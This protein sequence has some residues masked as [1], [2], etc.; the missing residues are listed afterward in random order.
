MFKKMGLCRV[1]SQSKVK[2]S[3]HNLAKYIHLLRFFSVNGMSLPC[4][5]CIGL[6]LILAF[7]YCNKT[8]DSKM[9]LHL[10]ATK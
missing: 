5:C 4:F 1:Y 2:K 8:T 3:P 7:C 6:D 10:M 9:Y